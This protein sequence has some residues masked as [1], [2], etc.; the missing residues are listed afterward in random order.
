MMAKKKVSRIKKVEEQIIKLSQELQVY[1]QELQKY[2]HMLNL[3]MN[4]INEYIL[5]KKDLGGFEKHIKDTTKKEEINEKKG[6][7]E[8]MDND[9]L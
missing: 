8:R 2:G 3:T 9:K 6:L 4:T 5:Y 1:G 7:S